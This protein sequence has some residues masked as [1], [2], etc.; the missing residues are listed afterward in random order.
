MLAWLDLE[1]SAENG[2]IKDIGALREDQAVYHG[3][4]MAD[5]LSFLQGVDTLCGHNISHHDLPLIQ[6]QAGVRWNGRIIDTLYLSPLLFP[7]HPYHALLKDDKLQVDELNNPVNDCRK[8]EKLYQDELNAFLALP[9]GIQRI[10]HALLR[11]VPEFRDFWAVLSDFSDYIDLPAEIRREWQ[12]LIC[13][14]AEL[15]PLIQESP[16]ELAY[17]LA[18]IGTRDEQSVTPAWVL[19][20]YPR[21][22]DVLRLLRGVPCR[23][24]CPYCDQ[25]LNLHRGLQ[26]YFGY[27]AFRTYDGEPL[28]EDAARAA[29]DGESL[30]AIF[31]T[32]GG[33]SIT[34]QL[35]ALMQGEALHGLT[36]VISPLQSLEKD[37]VDHLMATGITSAVTINGMLSPVERADACQRVLNGSACLLFISPEQLRSKTIERLLQSRSIV[38]FVIDEA[39]C[40]S[41]WGQDFRVDYLY[42][43]DFIRN[44]QEQRQDK[45]PIPVSCFTA[46]AKQKVIS[47]IRDYFHQKLN[48]DLSL[49]ASSAERENLHYNVL[50]QETDQ[51][52]YNTIRLLVSERQCPTIIYCS[53]T[54]RTREV[55]DK[56][57]SDGFCARAFHGKM[58]P[59]E[60]IA[61]QEAFLS[62]QV[63]IMV[64]TSAFGMGVD[65]KDVGLVIHYDISDSLENYVQE[66]GRAGRDPETQ[67][68]CYVLFNNNDLDKHFLLLNQTRLS[69]GEIQQ[70]WK[71]IKEL[72]RGRQDICCSALEIARQAGW[73]ASGPEME[74][75]V[76][77]AVTALENAG[78]VRRG[79]NVPRIYA[80]GIQAATMAEAGDRVRASAL[81][82][83]A[84]KQNALRILQFLISRRSIAKAGNDEAESRIDYIADLLGLEKR[85]VIDVIHLLRREGLLADTQDMSAYVLKF[86]GRNKSA[87]VLVHFLE[88]ERFLLDHTRGAAEPFDLKALN[89][90]ALAAGLSHSSVRNIRTILYFWAIKGYVQKGENRSRGTVQLQWN[91]EERALQ[92]KFARR[93]DMAHFAV[94][95]L[96]DLAQDS[97]ANDSE[98]VPVSFSLIG[99]LKKYNS[100]PRQL[101][102]LFPA[103]EP[104]LQDLEDALLYLSKIGA[105]QLEGGFLVLYNGMEIHRIEMDNRIR[106][107]REDYRL[108]DAFYQQ[109]IQQIHIVGQYA[110]MM[111]QSYAA[112]QKF[113]QDYFRMDYQRFI[114]KYFQDERAKEINLN[115]T[116][117][118]YKQLFGNL[119][120]R[121]EE[122]ISDAESRC[123]VVAA[124]PGSGKTRV[125]VH[126]LASLL[127]M[128]DVKHEQLLM[129]TFSRA[130]ATEFKKRLVELIGNA[131][132]FVEIKTFHSWCFD[133]LGR[134]GRLE[135]ADRVVPAAVEMITQGEVEPEKIR[136]TVLVID[137]AQDMD[138]AEFAL[139]R[140]LMAQ[141]EGMR[142]IAVGDDDQN[143]YEFRGSSAQYLRQLSQ[144]PGAKIYE[145]TE[146]YRSGS[147][148][149]ALENSFALGMKSRMKSEPLRAV[150][151]EP[152]RVQI[153]RHAGACVAYLSRQV[154]ETWQGGSAA[155]LTS[156]NEE[157]LQIFTQ[158]RLEGLPAKLVQGM[159]GFSLG[160]LLEI[161]VFLQF[162]DLRLRGR[163]VIS[164]TLWEQ[165][166][167]HTEHVC[168]G[169]E[170]LPLMHRLWQ[171]YERTS[172]TYYRSDLENFILESR[173]D[174]FLMEDRATI[175][176]ST[177][178]KAKG[179]EFDQVY[180]LLQSAR[181]NTEE[182]KRRVYVG[183][184]RARGELYI[185]CGPNAFPAP[186][187][188]GVEEAVNRTM[189]PAPRKVLLQLGHRD[190]AL[191]YFKTRQGI[192]GKMH[193]G[194][195]L[196]VDGEYLTA[197]VNGQPLRIGKLSRACVERLEKMAGKG[198]LPIGGKV[199]HIVAW[200]AP[201]DP[202]ECWI[203]LP[204]LTLSRSAKK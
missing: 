17:A 106:F 110:N 70:V 86:E 74:T 6:Q 69:M 59:A 18:V 19:R 125:L 123:I 89:E 51:E 176:V 115:I 120:S 165:A 151:E 72:T 52:K 15:D 127:L 161:R 117:Q 107:K 29:L 65:K 26:K 76:K 160:S 57:N 177:I 173:D 164:S 35:P 192:L 166:K 182:E 157:A 196:R 24:G 150:R 162:L 47:D 9:E 200:K 61:N 101:D 88:L 132:Y 42:I 39:H 203:I 142:V 87:S 167:A 23:E 191:S 147:A 184:T 156:T 201:E 96:Y 27:T 174:D 16:V 133:L 172:M 102:L 202:E 64:A 144:E 83:E 143:I 198:Y 32:G 135:E 180:L 14:H 66:A 3:G 146:N 175:L 78:Y 94:A 60:K 95:E 130:A 188:E 31:P 63:Q 50:F 2:V 152:G 105:V 71:A 8:A 159:D 12:G 92:E 62:N 45:R 171:D 141:N 30:L 81:F 56:L 112:A 153:T 194:W 58:T 134:V 67:A 49:F 136:K 199:R 21:T 13:A 178:H 85:E 187:P 53:R 75:R 138:G 25:R 131:A 43:G 190:V 80:S 41:A 129:L 149:I 109:K 163:P 10:Y 68:E 11:E 158:L 91:L 98:L 44:L 169:S 118:K 170:A 46:T 38:R 104:T 5:L 100:L 77:T 34:F 48:Q 113:V 128:E 4:S 186:L 36:V 179:R 1:A 84:E 116:P 126:K 37:Q 204:D 103:S 33:K 145:M 22:A 122:I 168:E 79:R 155:V 114:R 73:D 55:A 20:N 137:E 189:E 40:F 193:A 82:T 140:A 99:L 7:K 111:V 139:V 124:G 183:M 154:R 108:L 97:P 195:P 119:S 90:A 93:K 185:H 181:M 121:Q 54:R 148:I 28:Q 197:E